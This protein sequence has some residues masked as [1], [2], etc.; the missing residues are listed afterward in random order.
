MRLLI[1]IF[2][3]LSIVSCNFSQNENKDSIIVDVRT[4]EEWQQ[5]GHA[6]C[7][8]NYPLDQFESKIEE[9][10]EIVMTKVVGGIL[11]T[12]KVDDEPQS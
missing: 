3:F 4:T 5:D 10:G 8:V 6:D 2:S 9:F 12:K 11:A 1:F 7:A